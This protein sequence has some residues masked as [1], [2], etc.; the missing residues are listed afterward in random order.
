MP[1]TKQSPGN[2]SP[3]FLFAAWTWRGHL[4]DLLGRRDETLSSYLKALDHDPG[5]S[6]EHS[7][8]HLRI[9]RRWVETRLRSPFSWKKRT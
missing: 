2:P 6:M 3:I 8:Y 5:S 9:D 1:S 4:L 7:Q